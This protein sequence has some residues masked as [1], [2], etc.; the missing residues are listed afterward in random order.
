M[1]DIATFYDS[2]PWDILVSAA[3]RLHFPP[4]I[5]YLELLQCVAPRCLEQDK[6]ASTLFDPLLSVVQG[7]RS[8]T[9]FAKMMTHHVMAT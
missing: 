3:L 4:V 8:G 2:I 7:L 6:T 9:R 1:L 5:L